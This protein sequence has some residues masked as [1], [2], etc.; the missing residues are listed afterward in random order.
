MTRLYAAGRGRSSVWGYS[1]WGLRSSG[2]R[3]DLLPW[4]GALRPDQDG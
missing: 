1:G 2:E 3:T 4:S